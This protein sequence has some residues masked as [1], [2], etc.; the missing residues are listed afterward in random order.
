MR[1][2]LVLVGLA[3]LALSISAAGCSD[4]ESP[5]DPSSTLPATSPSPG[6]RVDGT[7]D[8]LGFGGTEPV[9]VKSNPDPLTGIVVL[10]D[11]RIGVHPEEGGW[12]RIV[13][14]FRDT[15]P[16]ASIAYVP[17]VTACGSGLPVTLRGSAVLQVRFSQTQAHDD[18]GRPTTGRTTL[19]GPGGTIL[20]ARQ[21]CDFEGVVTWA[22]GV[23]GRQR[24][25]VTTL[26]SPRRLIIDIKQ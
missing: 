24:F 21:T 15:L 11:I 18:A 20:Q 1:P 17:N 2:H 22:L 8:P 9:T 10:S 16:G 12:D 13:F 3:T 19:D 23:S 6:A 7:V 4:A 14:E 26:S 25:K 5:R